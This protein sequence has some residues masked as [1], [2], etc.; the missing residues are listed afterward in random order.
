MLSKKVIFYF[1]ILHISTKSGLDGLK[2]W[3]HVPIINVE[4]TVSQI[5]YLGLRATFG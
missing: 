2:V 1:L 4:G 5:F 3:L